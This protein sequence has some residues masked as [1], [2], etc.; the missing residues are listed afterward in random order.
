MTRF[1]SLYVAGAIV[2]FPLDMLWL[3]VIA[4]DVYRTQ[5]GDLLLPQ[6][7]WGVAAGFYVLYLAGLVTFVM[8]PA[9]Q[10]GS[11]LSAAAYGAAFGLVAYATYDLTNLATLRGFSMS[12]ALTD[13]AWGA[14]LSAVTAAGGLALASLVT[15]L[16]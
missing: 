16:R 2:F 12:L 11:W 8:L 5:L 10:N 15:N 9:A 6:P 1:L 3:G 7:H 14:V 13:M 4:R